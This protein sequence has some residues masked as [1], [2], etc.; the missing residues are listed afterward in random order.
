MA[1]DVGKPVSKLP[2]WPSEPASSDYNERSILPLSPSLGAPLLIWL[3]ILFLSLHLFL[4]N[5]AAVGPLLAIWL[6]V[7]SLRRDQ[8]EVGGIGRMVGWCSLVA[9]G[10][11]MVL[12]LIQGL[13]IWLEGGEAYFAALSNVWNSKVIYGFW[14]IG[15]SAV[16][17]VIYLAW[18][19]FGKRAAT[20]Q[21]V[22]SRFL[23]ILAA[24]NLLYHFPT[25][26]TIVGM[27]A[28]GE[29]TV[30]PPVDS[31]EFRT[32]LVQGEVIWFTLHFWFASF[33][34]S[35]LLTGMF[36]LKRLPEDQR[37][38]TAGA[39][40]TIALV[41]TLLQ[42]PVGFM[43]TTSLNSGQ[44][45]RLMGGDPL[46]TALFA[47]SLGMALWLMHLLATL[48]FFERDAKKAHQAS[49]VL[50]GTIL[51]MTAAMLLSRGGV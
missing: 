7:R 24:T 46:C 28:R 44:Q 26:F 43:L 3:R 11:G 47:I 2:I 48:A 39:A 36:C 29:V 51:L 37:E 18:W 35:G 16:C 34:V 10:L 14:E 42:I 15:F 30:D 4:M 38:A 31:G 49:M 23:A 40:F 6:D 45:S 1:L 12:G 9:F 32:L 22:L 27:M 41:P 13:L 20:W 5:L 21:R 19:Q 33:A 25:L 8:P 17:L 50:G